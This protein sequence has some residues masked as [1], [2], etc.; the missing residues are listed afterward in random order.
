MH[1]TYCRVA[2]VPAANAFRNHQ[3]A[4]PALDY[5]LFRGTLS[6]LFDYLDTHITP[7]ESLVLSFNHECS[8]SRG[9]EAV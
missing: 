4:P 8:T 2:L 6:I 1:V 7:S 3:E 9:E 5:N